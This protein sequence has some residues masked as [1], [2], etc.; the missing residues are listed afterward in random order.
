ME[1]HREYLKQVFDS[2][3]HPSQDKI[4]QLADKHR[5][6][7]EKF[8]EVVLQYAISEQIQF[9]YHQIAKKIGV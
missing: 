5:N 3:A 7:D 4:K 6:R 8:T 2:D 9:S 1:E